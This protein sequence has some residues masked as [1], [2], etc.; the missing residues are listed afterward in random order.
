MFGMEG[1]AGIHSKSNSHIHTEAWGQHTS[2]GWFY[3]KM[4]SA[5]LEKLPMLHMKQV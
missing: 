4:G 3:Q 2:H 1:E 5:F